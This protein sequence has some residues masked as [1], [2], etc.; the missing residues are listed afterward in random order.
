[1]TVIGSVRLPAACACVCGR[2]IGTPTVR[3]GA[4]T[5]K[6]MRSTS[7]TSTN[8]VTLISAIGQMPATRLVPAAG[9]DRRCRDDGHQAAFRSSIW[10]DRIA[11]NS[12][13]KPSMRVAS[14][15]TCAENLL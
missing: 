3:S 5:M 10:R 11:A 15:D 1:M 14:R 9:R 12:S 2:S 13:A 8:G 6:T 7:I 4:A